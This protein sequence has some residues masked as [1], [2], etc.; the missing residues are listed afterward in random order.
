M[1]VWAQLPRERELEWVGRSVEG[2]DEE[3]LQYFS[4]MNL[5]RSCRIFS[6]CR[7]TNCCR[8]I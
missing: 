8:Q 1:S 4:S 6:L 3:Y 2:V 5:D 7:A